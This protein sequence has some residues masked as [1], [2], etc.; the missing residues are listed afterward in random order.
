MTENESSRVISGLGLL[1]FYYMGDSYLFLKEDSQS[2]AQNSVRSSGSNFCGQC[3]HCHFENR[4]ECLKPIEGTKSSPFH[5]RLKNVQGE[6]L[7]CWVLSLLLPFSNYFHCGQF[8]PPHSTLVHSLQST[9]IIISTL[10]VILRLK[11]S[12]CFIL[13]HGRPFL[14]SN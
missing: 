11:E 9:K 7:K 5:L 13:T 10:G 1:L 4:K 14:N 12:I 2:L 8:I 6:N 3:S